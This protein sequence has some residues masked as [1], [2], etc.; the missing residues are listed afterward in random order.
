MAIGKNYLG[1]T[2]FIDHAPSGTVWQVSLLGLAGVTVARDE[3]L[4]LKL[5]GLGFDNDVD[6]RALRLPGL[7][8][9]P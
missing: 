5:L 8:R 6:D 4:E 1:A 9:L 7:G 3:G 2:T